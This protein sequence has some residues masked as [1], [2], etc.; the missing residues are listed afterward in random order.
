MILGNYRLT[1]GQGLMIDNT[2]EWWYRQISRTWGLHPD[3]TVSRQFALNGAAME[4]RYMPLL[5]Y[6]FFSRTIRD[7]YTHPDGTPDM[8]G[9]SGYRTTPMVGVLD[10][11]VMG[12]YAFL[13]LGDYL[14]VGTAVGVGGMRVT[15][16]DSLEPGS[17]WIDIPGDGYAWDC[18]EYDALEPSD[19]LSVLAASAQTVI[20]PFSVEGE[21]ARQDNEAIAG[22]TQCRWQ[23]DYFY[24]VGAFRHYDIGYTNPFCRGFAEQTRYD[25]TVFEKPYYLN[26]PMFSGMQDWPTPKPEEGLYLESRFQLSQHIVFPKLYLDVWRSLPYD[27]DN[28]RFQGEMEYRPVFPLRFRLKYKFQ[29]KTK[30][31]DV[32]PTTSRT[33]EMTLRCFSLPEG[34]DYFDIRLRYGVVILTPNPL[35]GDDRL[36]TG[37]YVTAK[38]EH[39]FT[40]SFSLLGGT[41]LW[42]TN[43]MSQWEFEDT[44]IDFLDGRGTKFYVTIKNVISDNLQLRLRFLRKDTCFPHT[45]LYRPDPDDQFYYEGNGEG[46]VPDFGDHVTSYG[47]RCQLDFRW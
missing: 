3:L 7:A 40:E 8:L 37:G 35:Y 19:R 14:P 32:V 22:H 23:N 36:M 4:L 11:T 29:D 44:G 10:E 46:P 47:I 33:Q 34:R 45:G 18:P 39:H 24:L 26:D 30:M 42:T 38:W 13:D 1:L 17:E 31:H 27:F 21:L 16:S 9:M 25:D 15:W 28:Y 5:G 20:G 12:A 43:G 6:G 41:T 2:D